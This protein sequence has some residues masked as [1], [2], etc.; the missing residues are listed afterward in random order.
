MG[1]AP[2]AS[3]ASPAPTPLQPEPEF[4][5]ICKVCDR[6]TLE[7]KNLYRLSRPVVAI[8]YILLLP[9]A[10]GI[11]LGI[12]VSLSDSLG[13]VTPYSNRG[14]NGLVTVIGIGVAVTSFVAGLLG[15]LL[16]MKKRV[17]QCSMCGATV[18][19]S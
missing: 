5:P 2:P 4:R 17:L 9:S 13:I 16:V 10:L 1:I 18:S 11:F 14:N 3:A 8:G 19:A 15:W 7:R 12:V 6:G